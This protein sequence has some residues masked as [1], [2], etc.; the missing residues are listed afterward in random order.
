MHRP[1]N[2]T[3]YYQNDRG[4]RV[5]A[6]FLT[7]RYKDE[8]LAPIQSVRIGREPLLIAG[9]IG[10]G[11]ALFAN[12]FG[13]LLY[14][15]EQVLLVCIGLAVIGAGYCLATLRIGQYMH[16]RTV[17]WATIW[18]VNAVRHAIVEAKQEETAN[19]VQA[20]VIEDENPE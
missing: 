1:A 13:D 11:L 17:L 16:E 10:G 4:I 18:T 8:A 5:T 14:R 12:R 20:I 3:I 15:H 6:R 19:E 7:T 9:L 2:D